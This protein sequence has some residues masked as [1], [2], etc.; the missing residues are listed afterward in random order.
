MLIVAASAG[1]PAVQ[2]SPAAR[3]AARLI[4]FFRMV[5]TRKKTPKLWTE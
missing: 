5:F 3:T 4:V 1:T 2:A